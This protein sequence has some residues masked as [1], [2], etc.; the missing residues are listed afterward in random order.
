MEIVDTQIHRPLPLAPW[1]EFDPYA[2][3]PREG[4]DPLATGP[5]SR[6]AMA[7]GVEL[8]LAVMEAVG[9]EDF[10]AYQAHLEVRADA[11]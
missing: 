5:S 9:V 2:G 10:S 7:V 1:P 4:G 3:Y 11:V 8:A 6:A